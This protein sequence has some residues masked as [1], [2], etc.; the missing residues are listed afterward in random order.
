MNPCHD[1]K[2]C[3]NIFPLLNKLS[4]THVFPDMLETLNV[5]PATSGVT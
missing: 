1:E 4:Y 3:V 5:K 2:L